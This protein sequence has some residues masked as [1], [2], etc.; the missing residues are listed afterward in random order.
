M[1]AQRLGERA[2]NGK[3]RFRYQVQRSTFGRPW[4]VVADDLPDTNFTDNNVQPGVEYEYRVRVKNQAGQFGRFAII[5]PVSSRHGY[6]RKWS[7]I[8][9]FWAVLKRAHTKAYSISYKHLQQHVN[10][11]VSEQVSSAYTPAKAHG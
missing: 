8:E 2:G 1:T 10:E 5:G 11:L 3:P 6:T 7:P 9:S 4:R